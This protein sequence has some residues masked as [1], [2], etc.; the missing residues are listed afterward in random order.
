MPSSLTRT[1][2]FHADH[3]FWRPDW[4]A[5][6]NRATF[7]AASEAPGHGHDYECA[8]TVSGPV[9]RETGMIVDLAQ[10][11][12]ILAE[13]VVGPLDGRHFNRDVPTFAY[14]GAIP[15]GEVVAAWLFGRIA[16]RL[17]AGVRLERVRIAEDPFLY[18]ECTGPA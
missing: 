1:V 8:V 7:G 6:R 15:T 17:P 9:D 3:H 11:D 2:R 12:R 13:E 16:A 4:P 14:G 5:E 18:A 10:L